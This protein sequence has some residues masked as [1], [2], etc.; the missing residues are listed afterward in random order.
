MGLI[1]LQVPKPEGLL[2]GRSMGVIMHE[3]IWPQN[4]DCHTPV[5]SMLLEWKTNVISG[6]SLFKLIFQILGCKF[7]L[8]HHQPWDLEASTPSL[9]NCFPYLKNGEHPHCYGGK[10]SDAIQQANACGP[11]ALNEFTSLSFLSFPHP[12]LQ[13]RP[14]SQPQSFSTLATQGS[15][16]GTFQK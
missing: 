5:F 11:D 10:L 9:S 8:C 4:G 1:I 16:W 2:Q 7:M 13:L 14:P 6:P 15:P 12:M 3:R